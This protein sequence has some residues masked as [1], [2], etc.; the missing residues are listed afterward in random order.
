M[1]VSRNASAAPIGS[2]ISTMPAAITT[3]LKSDAPEIGIG[4]YELV[5]VEA[6]VALRIEE[7]RVEEAL[8]EYQRQRREHHQ[9]GD[10]DDRR[11]RQAE[12]AGDHR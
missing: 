3:E 11:A 2:A 9:R 4:E 7:R 1:R 8:P 6:D 12:A 5:G 10:R